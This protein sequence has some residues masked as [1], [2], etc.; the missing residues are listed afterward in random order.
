MLRFLRADVVGRAHVPGH[1]G[2]LLAANHRSFL[3]HLILNAA[4]P[5]PMYFLGKSSMA[6]GPIGRFNIRMGMIPVERGHADLSA[7][8]VVV[9]YLRAGEVVGVFPEGTR[10]PTGHLYRFRSGLARIAAAAQ[11]P[12]VPAGLV[13]TAETLPRGQRLPR[14]LPP[15]RLL[16]RFGPVV[17]PP[18][19]DAKERR[20]FTSTVHDRVA[21]LCGQPLADGF[22]PVPPES[23]G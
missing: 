9:A 16:I 3:D 14:R 2:V 7:L 13:G 22:A 18:S 23:A 17:A 15:G 12:V 8:D 19:T 11:V 21:E 6:T 20:A 1:G 4:S 10:S 5:R